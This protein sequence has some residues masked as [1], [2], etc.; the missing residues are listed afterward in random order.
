MERFSEQNYIEK[1]R[2]VIVEDIKIK[3]KLT[4]E[5]YYMICRKIQEGE[6]QKFVEE[7]EAI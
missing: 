7:G 3:V 5:D 4:S 6:T 1:E 2:T